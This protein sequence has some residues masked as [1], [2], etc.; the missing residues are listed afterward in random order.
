MTTEQESGTETLSGNSDM[1]MPEDGAGNDAVSQ[2]GGVGATL[3]AARESKRLDIAHIAAETRIPIHHLEVIE[4]GEFETLPSRTYAIGFARNYARIVDLDEDE[5]AD[6]VRA[7]LSDDGER[8]VYAADNMEPGDPAKLPSSGLAWF[9]ALAA[10]VLVIGIIAFS[11]SYFG[12]GADLPPLTQQDAAPVSQENAGEA[13]ELA[14]G[15]ASQGSASAPAG[16]APS[17]EVVF[18]AL[19]DGV[20][21]R[22]Y[23]RGG[24]RLYEAQMQSGETFVL[25]GD[26]TEPLI[27]TGRPDAFAITIGGRSVPKLAQEPQTMGGEPVS[28]TALLAR[29]DTQQGPS[30]N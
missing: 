23:E 5:I 10:I 26:A 15:D 27:N 22:F 7:E 8:R 20:W 16:P 25:P 2:A 6:A 19:E 24:D 28:A 12:Q 29:S 30:V 3:R 21:V 1:E 18:T 9:G 14:G 17:G 11:T 13:A 4:A